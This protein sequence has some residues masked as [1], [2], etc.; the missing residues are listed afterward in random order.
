M[1]LRTA[2]MLFFAAG[3][4]QQGGAGSP[5]R[6]GSATRFVVSDNNPYPFPDHIPLPE[7][8]TRTTADSTSFTHYLRTLPLKKDKTVYLFNGQPKYNQS[9]QFAV[10]NVSVGKQDLQQCADAVMRLRAEYLFARQNWNQILFRDNNGKAYAFTPPYTRVHFDQ[11]LQQVFG[12]CG[13]ASLEKQLQPRSWAA[14]E[15]GDVLIRGGFPGHAVLVVDVAENAQHEKIFLLAQSYMPAQDIHLL[16]NP[17]NTGNS[18]WYQADA[19]NDIVT[20]EWTFHPQALR[21]W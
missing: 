3:C 10:F 5:A 13:S 8:F 4:T 2:I 20:P 16:R 9:A 1:R 7:G 19:V 18:P 12:M 15:P 21:T 11:Y 6:S 17:A 14:L